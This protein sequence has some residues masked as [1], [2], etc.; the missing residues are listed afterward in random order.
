[1]G[2]IFASYGVLISLSVLGLICIGILILLIAVASRSKPK[3]DESNESS[4]DISIA[5]VKASFLR[6]VQQIESSLVSRKERHEI[7][8]VLVLD[9]PDNSFDVPLEEAGCTSL[10]SDE[11]T[12]SL[13]TP[14]LQWHILEQGVVVEVNTISK[15]SE[16]EGVLAT[17]LSM[18]Q[19]YRPEKIVLH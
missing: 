7:P 6:A 13:E 8:W 4:A 3:V 5:A 17:F 18:V 9:E 1:M 2:Q 11:A 19:K 14:G 10:I 12:R 15:G 16:R